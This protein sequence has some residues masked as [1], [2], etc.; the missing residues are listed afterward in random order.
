MVQKNAYLLGHKNSLHIFRVIPFV[1]LL[2]ESG[3]HRI[4]RG[5]PCGWVIKRTVTHAILVPC[6]MYLSNVHSHTDTAWPPV[7]TSVQL[8]DATTTTTRRTRA[9][10][11]I[12]KQR[13][14]RVRIDL[15]YKL[16]FHCHICLLRRHSENDRQQCQI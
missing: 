13:A 7:T 6:G 1:K 3:S 15:L 8:D 2:V 9:L 4:S 14:I 12:V 11:L 10:N 5:C 16:N